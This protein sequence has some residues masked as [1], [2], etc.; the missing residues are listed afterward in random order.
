[1]VNLKT[2]YLEPGT[3]L[4]ANT[5]TSTEDDTLANVTTAIPYFYHAHI[6]CNN[7]V[8]VTDFN[9]K[10][11]TRGLMSLEET[12]FEF[13]GQDRDLCKYTDIDQVIEA[14]GIIKN[15]F[16]KLSTSKISNKIE[17]ELTCLGKIPG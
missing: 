10:H 3:P 16:T 17:P 1:M 2:L 15:R 13:V 4:I 9:E 8:T 11:K 6:G 7:S 12:N 5:L 14:A